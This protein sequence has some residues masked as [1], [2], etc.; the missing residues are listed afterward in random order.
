MPPSIAGL[1]HKAIASASEIKWSQWP[2]KP[3]VG[4]TSFCITALSVRENEALV[5]RVSR[6]HTMTTEPRSERNVACMA[7]LAIAHRCNRSV[8]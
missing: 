8:W 4:M 6:R 2:L 7:Q 1:L 3:E 5:R